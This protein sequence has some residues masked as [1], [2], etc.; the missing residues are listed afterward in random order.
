M[1]SVCIPKSKGEADGSD[2]N[3]KLRSQIHGR[4][5]C[6]RH[7]G[8]GHGIAMAYKSMIKKKLILNGHSCA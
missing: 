8:A 4:G 7:Q 5:D 2:S 6:L 3:L 1:Q